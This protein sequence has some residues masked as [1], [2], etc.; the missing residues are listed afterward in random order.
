M[1]ALLA[2]MIALLVFFIAV[3]DRPYRGTM[4]IPA[5]AYELVLDDLVTTTAP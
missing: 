1:T 5:S 2:T 3:T 4:G